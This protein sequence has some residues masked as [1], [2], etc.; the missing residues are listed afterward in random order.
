LDCIAREEAAAAR[1]SCAEVLAYLR[2][3][4]YFFLDSQQALGLETFRRLA[5]ELGMDGHAVED[6]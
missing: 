1:L 2:D 4:L 3:N 5:V 6:T